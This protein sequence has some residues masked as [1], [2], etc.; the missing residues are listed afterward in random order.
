MNSPEINKS[1]ESQNPGRLNR[2]NSESSID[3]DT[4]RYKV[5]FKI[6]VP[7]LLIVI[8]F[9]IIGLVMVYSASYDYSN[10]FY[11]SPG[12]IFFRQLVWMAIGLVTAVILTFFDYH[13]WRKYAVP[14]MGLTIFALIAVIIVNEVRNGAVRTL[15]GGSIQPSELAK[16][17]III[18]LAVWLSAKR[19]KLGKIGFGLFPLAMILGLFGGLI[20]IQPD[21]SAVATIFILGGLLFFLAGGDL[22]QIGILFAIALIIGGVIIQLSP[23]GATRIEYFL[24]GLMDPTKGSYHVRRSLEAIIKG[25]WFGVGIGKAETK[26]TGLPVPPTDSIFAVVGE[27]T[28]VFGS[29]IVVILFALLLWRG[30]GIARS[31]HDQL[32]MLLAAGLTLWISLE[33]FINM[34]VMVNLMPFAGNA[35][36][37]ISAGGSNLTVTLAAV[38]II[39]NISRLSESRKA[40]EGKSINAVIDLRRRNRRRRLSGSRRS[41][42]SE[43]A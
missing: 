34:A 8:A 16:L 40:E 14:A 20:I 21:F 15:F 11:G 1:K 39:F 37:F 38:G 13:R 36:P 18:Y 26:L 42:G 30:F 19:D 32:G 43:K 3:Q 35:L 23:T 25:G 6:D 17:V 28:G 29:T 10:I 41:A 5:Q 31:A 2:A 12:T 9:L 4:R 33:A 27:E 7:L 24:T 22:K